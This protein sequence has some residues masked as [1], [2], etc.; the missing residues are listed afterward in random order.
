LN[1]IPSAVLVGRVLPVFGRKIGACEQGLAIL[2][3]ALGG[4]V[5]SQLLGCDEGDEGDLGNL[6]RSAIWI[7]EIMR[8][9]GARA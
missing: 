5:V 8:P 7:F 3:Q 1:T 9:V 2:R 4:V 6:A